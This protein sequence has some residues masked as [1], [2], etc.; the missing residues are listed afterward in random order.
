VALKA[1]D[2]VTIPVP[3]SDQASNV[4][5]IVNQSIAPAGNTTW[6]AGTTQLGSTPNG[7]AGAQGITGAPG[8]LYPFALKTT[9]P[10]GTTR[11]VGAS[12]GAAAVDAL[13]VQPLISS[14]SVTGTGGDSTLYSSAATTTITRQV[15]V[16]KGFALQQR[17]FD[18]NGRPVSYG[19]DTVAGNDSGQVTIVAGGFTVVKLVQK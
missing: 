13:L 5:P 17:A 2:T 14:V 15:V 9:M 11:V 6:A 7:G 10:A 16:P 12:D 3:A 8:M 19:P 4:Y 1:G 18:S